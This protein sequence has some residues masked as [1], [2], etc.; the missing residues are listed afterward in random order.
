MYNP[1]VSQDSCESHGEQIIKQILKKQPNKGPLERKGI[2]WVNKHYQNRGAKCRLAFPLLAHL[3]LARIINLPRIQKVINNLPIGSSGHLLNHQ[4]R[5]AG[6]NLE[7]IL[8]IACHSNRI[9][10]QERRLVET[11]DGLT[12]SLCLKLL[13]GHML[14]LTI[15]LKT[16]IASIHPGHNV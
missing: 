11:P 12:P 1:K 4:L 15:P 14:A 2:K 6:K 3:V 9:E 16:V 10:R 7:N 8:R 5:S 13:L